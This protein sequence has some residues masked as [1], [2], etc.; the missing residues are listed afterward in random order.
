MEQRGMAGKAKQRRHAGE[1]LL[2]TPPSYEQRIFSPHILAAIVAELC[3]Q[4]IDAS[5]SLEGTDITPS[6]LQC[7]TTR[8]SYRQLDTATRNALRLSNDPMIALRAGQRM[9][10][11]AYG[12]YGY[13]LMSSATSVEARAF[14]VRYNRIVGPFC[15]IA[16]S[17]DGPMIIVTIEPT[18]WSNPKEDAHHF[19]VE[20]ALSAH[21]N[22]IR[23][24]EGRSFRFSRVA[25]NYTASPHANLY[26]KLLE[27]PVLFD[28]GYCGYEYERD[29]RPL[30]LADPRSHA[31]AREMCEHLLSEINHAGGAAADIRR[32]LI[33]QPGQ[34]PGID[35]IADKLRMHPRALRRKLQ[36]EGTSY[37]E[38]QAEVR[39]GLAIEYLRRTQMTN[40]EI[41]SRIGYSDA[42]NFRH[43]FTR[44]TGKS[45]SDF[46]EGRR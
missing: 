6:Q 25:L 36:A 18:H 45:P 42:A 19:A 27:C 22:I 30:E 35:A 32:I 46:R 3:T 40:E 1:P 29:D 5:V 28:Q 44:W 41:A 10:I 23:D 24:R 37:R 14:S 31:M 43:A 11:T 34:Y 4:G 8:I 39:M 33:E 7:H 16:F 20:F 13:A 17:D 15:D 38:L 26:Q 12:M 2:R 9:R 21:L